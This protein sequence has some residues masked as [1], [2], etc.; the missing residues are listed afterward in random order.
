M[1]VALTAD[2][3]KG[4]REICLSAGMDDYVTKPLKIEALNSILEMLFESRTHLRAAA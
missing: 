2:V 4:E 1:I 3:L